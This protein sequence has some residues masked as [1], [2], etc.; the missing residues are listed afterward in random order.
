M[1]SHSFFLYKEIEIST[2]KQNLTFLGF[3][4]IIKYTKGEEYEIET[5]NTIKNNGQRYHRENTRA[6]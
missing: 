5:K 4:G 6:R 2:F 3:Y 1:V